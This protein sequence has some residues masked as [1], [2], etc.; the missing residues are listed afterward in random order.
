[1]C[2]DRRFIHLAF[3]DEIPAD[4][5]EYEKQTGNYDNADGLL[6]GHFPRLP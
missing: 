3:V 5:D 2:S 1:M 4:S 6:V